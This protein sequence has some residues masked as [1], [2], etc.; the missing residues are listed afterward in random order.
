MKALRIVLSNDF[1]G[2]V[3]ENGKLPGY[4]ISF[5]IRHE[6]ILSGRP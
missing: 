1:M 6:R 2:S 4:D 3:D 5:D